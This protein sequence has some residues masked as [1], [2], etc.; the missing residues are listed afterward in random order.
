MKNA[1]LTINEKFEVLAQECEAI[2][3]EAVF[4]SRQ[5]LIEG[6]HALGKRIRE[7]ETEKITELVK[8][9]AVRVRISERT[10][11]YAV[12]FYDKYPD[13]DRLPEGKNISWSKII[14]K[15]LPETKK[16]EE[17]QHQYEVVK[18]CVKCKAIFP[19]DNDKNK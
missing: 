8:S 10:L 13:L 4:A 3:T 1:I 11:W 12:Q 14:T 15:Y 17:C 16:E 5:L 19:L 6:Y 7:E 9:L 2:I 18:R